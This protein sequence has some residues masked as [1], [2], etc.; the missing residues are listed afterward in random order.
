[1]N[2]IDIASFAEG[3]LRD[4]IKEGKPVHFNAPQ[5]SDAPDVSEVSVPNT[6]AHQ[7][8]S[9]GHWKKANVIFDTPEL[10]KDDA[11]F[12]IV[13]EEKKQTPKISLTEEGLY[14]KHL[15]NEYKKKVSD[16]QD[17][18]GLMESLGLVENFAAGGTTGV[19]S[20]GTNM[21]APQRKRK[22]TKRGV[23][24]AHRLNQRRR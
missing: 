17:L 13:E 7:V 19:G 4:T 22:K 11:S 15:V 1:M 10:I 9:E 6:F 5:S 23:S 3:I 20:I 14:K 21:A 18:V 2:E 24:I 8:L 12:V 16:L